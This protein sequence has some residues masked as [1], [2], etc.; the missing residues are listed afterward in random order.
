MDTAL[1]SLHYL[2]SPCTIVIVLREEN[3]NSAFCPR[4]GLAGNFSCLL[5]TSELLLKLYTAF[6]CIRVIRMFCI[7]TTMQKKIDWAF[8]QLFCSLHNLKKY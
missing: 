2:F 8:I 4:P 1:P 7:I 5:A 6:P 3:S